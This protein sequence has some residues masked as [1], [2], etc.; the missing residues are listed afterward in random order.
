MKFLLYFL[1]FVLTFTSKSDGHESVKIKQEEVKQ[2]KPLNKSDLTDFGEINF[3]TISGDSISLSAFKGKIILLVNVASK[4]GLTP[5]Y[6][7]LEDLYQS[8]KDKGI[9]VIGFPANNFGNQE[10]GTNDEILNFCQTNYGV[11]FPMMAKISVKGEDKHPLYKYLTEKSTFTGEIE[12]NFSKFLIDQN[13]KV[14]ERYASQTKPK[15]KKI[16]EKIE[17]LL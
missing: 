17:S 6:K 11:T 4:C 14:V 16:I 2:E 3:L 10:P 5:Q 9:V 8:Y 13:G 7:D 12:W 1:I 15:S